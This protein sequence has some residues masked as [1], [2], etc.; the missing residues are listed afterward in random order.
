MYAS[1]VACIKCLSISSVDESGVDPP[2]EPP[3]NLRSFNRIDMAMDILP[4]T[5]LPACDA[6]ACAYV[7]ASPSATHTHTHKHMVAGL[8]CVAATICRWYFSPCVRIYL[9]D[10]DSFGLILNIYIIIDSFSSRILVCAFSLFI[11]FFFIFVFVHVSF[12]HSIQTYANRS[13]SRFSSC[14]SSLPGLE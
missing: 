1:F 5:N 3:I 11:F 4:E 9:G 7:N 13:Q 14:M 10:P 12:L 8:F 6:N 2:R